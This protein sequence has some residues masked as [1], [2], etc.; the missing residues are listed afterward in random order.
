MPDRCY[1]RHA[2]DERAGQRSASP[3]DSP[4]DFVAQVFDAYGSN[5]CR[6]EPRGE[7]GTGDR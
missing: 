1:P 5:G 2:S 4:P 6:R 7:M 3:T